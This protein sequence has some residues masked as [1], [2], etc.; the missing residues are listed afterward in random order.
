MRNL[1]SQTRSLSEEIEE[2]ENESVEEESETREEIENEEE[3]ILE[4]EIEEENDSGTEENSENSEQ[5]QTTEKSDDRCHNGN[6]STE[7][8]NDSFINDILNNYP[9]DN[10]LE[11]YGKI[12]NKYEDYLIEAESKINSLEELKKYD[13]KE[14]F[15]QICS[16]ISSSYN[17]FIQIFCLIAIIFI[18]KR[19]KSKSDFGSG[20]P[21]QM[22]VSSFQNMLGNNRGKGNI[23]NNQNTNGLSK[24]KQS[25]KKK[26][27]KDE[28]SNE[29][30]DQV[31]IMSKKRHKKRGRGSSKKK[32]K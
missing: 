18:I 31:R 11:I 2:N 1:D 20:I 5:E 9:D 28:E 15:A 6:C 21:T 25:K 22:G 8:I 29:E 24:K 12:Y 3:P 10:L 32:K 23:Y 14:N 26:S 7:R 30:S 27:K 16:Y 13:K 4:Y 19:I 17:G